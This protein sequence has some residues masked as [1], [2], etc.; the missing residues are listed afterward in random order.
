MSP[1]S[2]GCSAFDWLLLFTDYP[3]HE[4]FRMSQELIRAVLC[5]EAAVSI[6]QKFRDF[7]ASRLST[8]L[9]FMKIV[10][11]PRAAEHYFKVL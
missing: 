4:D 2:S 7:P 10:A 6:S 3:R 11:L 5:D 8:T 9:A 1:C